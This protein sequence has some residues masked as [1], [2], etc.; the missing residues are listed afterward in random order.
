MKKLLLFFVA[1]FFIAFSVNAQ[2][3]VILVFNTNLSDGTT[4][5]LPLH[6]TVDVTVDWG[7]SGGTEDFTTASDQDHL[8]ASEGTYTVT[9]SGSLT[10][11]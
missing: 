8:Y 2:N 1:I 6:G 9:I 5:T 7:D 4:I 3:D 11:F 10:Q